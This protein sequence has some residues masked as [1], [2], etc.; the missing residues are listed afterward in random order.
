MSEGF[1]ASASSLSDP[2]TT[3]CATLANPKSHAL[4]LSLSLTSK[5]SPFKSRCMVFRAWRYAS[6]RAM[7]VAK[8]IRRRHGKGRVR[9]RMY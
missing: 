6:A 5:F 2:L 8:L 9:S 4:S 7:S 1:L 3:A